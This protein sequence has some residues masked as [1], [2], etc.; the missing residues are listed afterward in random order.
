MQFTEHSDRF[1]ALERIGNHEVT[2]SVDKPVS[3]EVLEVVANTIEQHGFSLIEKSL[4]YVNENKAE[5][6]CAIIDDLSDPQITASADDLL[7]VW[8]YSA[9]GEERGTSII[10]VEFSTDCL[11]P[12]QIAVGD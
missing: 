5:Y 11:N 2:V 12:V 10:G 8:W 4:A 7:G 9:K 1:E 6:G 3:P